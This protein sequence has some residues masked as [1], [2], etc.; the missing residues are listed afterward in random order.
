MVRK[1]HDCVSP[2]LITIDLLPIY[3]LGLESPTHSIQDTALSQLSV[4]LP[5]LDFSTIKNELFPVVAQVFSKTSS[6]AIKIRGLEAFNVLCGGVNA[7]GSDAKNLMATQPKANSS[8][9]VLD[10]YTIQEKMVPLLKAIKTKEPAVMVRYES[11]PA[12]HLLTDH[13]WPRSRSSS[14]SARLQMCPSWPS[15]YCPYSGR[16]P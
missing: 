11:R 4:V 10:K 14:R 9:A 7:S 1:C 3:Y 12:E 16:S 6:M 13:R 15:T 5:V 8:S 2:K